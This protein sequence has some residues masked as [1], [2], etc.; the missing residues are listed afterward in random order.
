MRVG[1]TRKGNVG[2]F[3]VNSRGSRQNRPRARRIHSMSTLAM[4][5][6]NAVAVHF[7]KLVQEGALLDK[8]VSSTS[9]ELKVLLLGNFDYIANILRLGRSRR[10]ELKRNHLDLQETLPQDHHPSR[11][12]TF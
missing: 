5:D 6:C 9:D 8:A 12:W 1:L 10:A 4:K 11:P 2:V 3:N 7:E